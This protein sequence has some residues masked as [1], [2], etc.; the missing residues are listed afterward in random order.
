MHDLLQTFFSQLATLIT[1]GKFQQDWQLCVPM[2]GWWLQR[3]AVKFYAFR[4]L[5]SWLMRWVL[6]QLCRHRDQKPISFHWST[7]LIDI[8]TLQASLVYKKFSLSVMHTTL[9][10]TETV[11]MFLKR[12]SQILQY[13]NKTNIGHCMNLQI[14]ELFSYEWRK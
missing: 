14:V 10:A 3:I 2:Y 8:Y 7:S 9:K 1:S 4:I 11:N 6:Y 5:T 13:N 12:Y